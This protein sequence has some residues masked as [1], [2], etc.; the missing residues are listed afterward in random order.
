ME[1]AFRIEI[2]KGEHAIGFEF[3]TLSEAEAFAETC[4]EACDQD[5]QVIM[6][7]RG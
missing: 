5:T 2:K 1:C 3:H 4:F 6:I 7:K